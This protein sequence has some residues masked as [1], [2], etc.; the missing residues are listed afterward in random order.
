MFINFIDEFLI[1]LLICYELDI[2]MDKSTLIFSV[3]FSR[4]SCGYS[5]SF[6]CTYVIF[7]KKTPYTKFLVFA[8]TVDFHEF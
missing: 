6:S 5:H 3:D 1:M 8:I 4:F 7:L 2:N